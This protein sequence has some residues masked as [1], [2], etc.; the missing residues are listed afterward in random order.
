VARPSHVHSPDLRS[1]IQRQASPFAGLSPASRDALLSTAVQH[2]LLAAV[3]DRLPPDDPALRTRYERIAAGARLRDARLR[4]VLEE[5]LG[6]LATADVVPVALKG[7]MLADRIYPDPA[8]RISSDLDLLVPEQ[9]FDRSV[10]AVVSL[11]FRRADPI[12]DAYQRRH[13]HHLQLGRDPG[14]AVELHFRPLSGFGA[15]VPAAELLARALPHWTRGGTPVLVLSPEDELITLAVHA[16]GHLMERTSW[17]LDLVLFLERHP[18]LDWPVV[19]DRSVAFRCRRAL[20]YAL[21][22]IRE[23][24]AP[25]PAAPFLA[26][27]PARRLLCARLPRPALAS[28]GR[29]GVVLQMAFHLA[30]RDRPWSAGGYIL[31]QAWWMLRRRAHLLAR[32]LTRGRRRIP[33]PP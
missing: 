17:L 13:E 22:E 28:K 30:M 20:A 10:T 18:R 25:V 15:V 33:G 9:A 11:G 26:L 27:D 23:L 24:G 16:A 4:E 12:V 8:L 6:V 29:L 32:R 3:A 5:V 21:G 14:P 1:L 31:V 19:G 7:P 2:G